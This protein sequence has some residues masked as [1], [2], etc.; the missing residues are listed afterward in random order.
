MGSCML[1]NKCQGRVYAC[2]VTGVHVNYGMKHSGCLALMVTVMHEMHLP[3][4]A[5]L[6]DPNDYGRLPQYIN[7][8]S[9]VMFLKVD[10]FLVSHCDQIVFAQKF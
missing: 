10:K 7:I 4:L 5:G 3:D 2:G 8:I 9:V 1:S 6:G